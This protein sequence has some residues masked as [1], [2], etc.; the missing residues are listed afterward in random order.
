VIYLSGNQIASIQRSD[1]NDKN[2]N[3][4]KLNL[5]NNVIKSIE[6]GCF[7]GTKIS[8]ISLSYNFLTT[9]PDFSEVKETLARV[10]L[11]ANQICSV[12]ADDVKDLKKLNTLSLSGNSLVL[13]TDQLLQ[14]SN[15]EKLYLQYTQPCTLL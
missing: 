9:F 11:G 6:S 10:D 14:L 13:I 1:F 3:L 12:F 2:P 8:E 5:R 7:R 4:S 15:R